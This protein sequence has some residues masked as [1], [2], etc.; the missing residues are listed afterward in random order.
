MNFAHCAII[1]SKTEL[2]MVEN[3]GTNYLLRIMTAACDD[4]PLDKLYPNP[5]PRLILARC[6]PVV[7]VVIAVK[8]IW[9]VV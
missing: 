7:L 1:G 9:P 8:V 6:W 5:E 2:I 4:L 3:R